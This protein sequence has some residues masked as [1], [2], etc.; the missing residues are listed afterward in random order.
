V[1]EKRRN[2]EVCDVCG[3]RRWEDLRLPPEGAPTEE[4]ALCF[5]CLEW[6]AHFEAV[7]RAKNGGRGW[8]D[9]AA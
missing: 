7:D 4:V 1:A 5:P 8:N 3:L 2:P 6:A 9:R